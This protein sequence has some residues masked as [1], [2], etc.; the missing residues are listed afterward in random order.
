MM[1]V[2]G[3]F[4][5]LAAGMG[6][7]ALVGCPG[8]Q[9]SDSDTETDPIDTDTSPDYF[10]PDTVLIEGAFGYDAATGQARSV[11]V[12]GGNEL[13]P[14]VNL[15]LITEDYDPDF[16]DTFCD[17]LYQIDTTA[18]LEP[19][20]WVAETNAFAGFDFAPE[21]FTESNCSDMEFD[22]E[23]WTDDPVA[24][25]TAYTWSPRRGPAG[26]RPARPA[27]TAG[28]ATA[29]PGGLGTPAGPPT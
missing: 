26:R 24:L 19:A 17:V 6:A 1:Y 27:R 3:W 2:N 16:E 7:V 14:Y 18:V 10:E 20:S 15:R 5:A 9:P 13:A 25:I 28:R 21:A 4:R 11:M 29:R 8:E 22:P 12:P 23:L